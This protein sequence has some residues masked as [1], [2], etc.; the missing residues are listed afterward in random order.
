[1]VVCRWSEISGESNGSPCFGT[2]ATVHSQLLATWAMG[3][4]PS[5]KKSWN[6]FEMKSVDRESDYTVGTSLPPGT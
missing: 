5:K 2:S 3:D 6:G 4:I 1:M